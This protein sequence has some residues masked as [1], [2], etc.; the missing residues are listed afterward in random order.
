M[1][2]LLVVFVALTLG[3]VR[4]HELYDELDEGDPAP[5]S[6]TFEMRW[7]SDQVIWSCQRSRQS[8][9]GLDTHINANASAAAQTQLELQIT[10][11]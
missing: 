1:C 6:A 8:S 5:V 10:K 9:T 7:P 3:S 2:T 4:V 11:Q